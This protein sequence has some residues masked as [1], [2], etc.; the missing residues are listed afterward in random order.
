MHR[1]AAVAALLS[2]AGVAGCPPAVDTHAAAQALLER[3]RAW[4]AAA[5]GG[6]SADSIVSFWSADARVIQPGAPV[7]TGTAAIKNM[8][9]ASLA[10]PGF[11]ISWM[12]DSAVVAKSGD[13]GYTF[14]TVSISIPDS[15]GKATPQQGHYVT[16]WARQ[17]DGL[18]RCTVDIAT[19]EP[20][21]AAGQS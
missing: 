3:D 8:V 21:P 10:A 20:G 18:W 19:Y 1:L 5:A 9:T 13:L 7:L 11:H 2:L 12:P 15:T 14:G 17:A 16:V 4:A 6:A